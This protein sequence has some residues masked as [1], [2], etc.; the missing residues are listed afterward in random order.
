[1]STGTYIPIDAHVPPSLYRHRHKTH[2]AQ[3]RNMSL[4]KII[5]LPKVKDAGSGVKPRPR[6]QCSL[7]EKT[8]GDH[9]IPY[10]YACC[11]SQEAACM[12][13]YVC[14]LG[15]DSN[16]GCCLTGRSCAGLPGSDIDRT[17]STSTT[18]SRS[19]SPVFQ[20]SGITIV[21]MLVI[22]LVVQDVVFPH[23][24]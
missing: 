18:N 13:G 12:Q 23:N 17:S 19:N 24:G 15:T 3:S 5:P 6:P 16:Y 22:S 20:I 4:S 14:F 2:Q 1:L 9:C 7:A 11:P 8:C 10:S 21:A